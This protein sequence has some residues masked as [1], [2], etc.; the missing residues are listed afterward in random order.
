M[1]AVV[2]DCAE[3]I[4]AVSNYEYSTR[5]GGL[6][7]TAVSTNTANFTAL[8]LATRRSYKDEMTGKYIDHT[9]WHRCIVWDNAKSLKNGSGLVVAIPSV[10]RPTPALTIRKFPGR[11]YIVRDLMIRGTLTRPFSELLADQIR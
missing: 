2:P 4:H 5:A 8:S 6:N 10:V 11:H 9:E 7:A 3:E 1:R